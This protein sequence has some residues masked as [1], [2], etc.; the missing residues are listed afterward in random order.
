VTSILPGAEPFPAE[1]QA[2]LDS[3]WAEHEVKHGRSHAIAEDGGSRY[4]NRL[5]L[6]GSPYLRQHAHNPVNWYPWGDEAFAAAQSQRRPVFL[7]IGYSTCHWCHVM[8]DESFADPAIAAFLNAHY[9]AIKVDREERPDIDAVYMRAAQELGGGGGWPLSVWLTADRRPFFAGTYFPPRAGVRGATIGLLEILTELVL[10]Y[11]EDQARVHAVAREV[12]EAVR[13]SMQS[14]RDSAAPTFSLSAERE[15]RGLVAAAVEACRTGFDERHGGLRL[16]QKFPS[17]VPIRL[18]LRHHLRTGDAHALHM[19]VRTLEGMAG[20][21]IYDHLAGGFHRYATDPGWQVPHFEKMLYDNALLVVAYAE[22][23]QVTKRPDFARVVRET[24]DELLATFASRQG[25]FW[26]A[27]DAD[28]EGV[29][30]RYFAWSEAEIRAV[31]GPGDQTELFL[32]HYG[33]SAAGNFELGNILHVPRLEEDLTERLAPSR[34]KLRQARG[35]RVPPLRDEKILAAWNGLTISAFAVAGRVFDEKRYIDAAAAAADFILRGM[36]DPRGGR[37][38]RSWFEG[39]TSGPGFL[40]D[41]A[42]V[43]AGLLDLFESTGDSR[44]FGEACSLAEECEGRFADPDL[45]GWFM[46]GEEHEPLL[47]RERPLRDGAEPSGAS[48]ALM[49]AA[50]LAVYTDDERWR[51]VAARAL[52]FYAPILEEHPMAMTEA[53]IAVDFLAG[54]VKE[55]VLALPEGEAASAKPFHEVLRGTF[56]PRKVVV[57]GAPGPAG[58]QGLLEH[59]PALRDK[60][61]EP[62]MATAYVCEH[63]ACQAPTSDPESFLHL[64]A[65]TPA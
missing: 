8:E 55:I 56:C 46:T 12:V 2:R 6:E 16:Q 53:L 44:W 24:C 18:C 51:Q 31:L 52:H 20:G 34:A 13:A 33:V 15:G 3:A 28:S 22:A 62:G 40:D 59:I 21:G 26:S 5:A 38:A 48:V 27:T 54:P 9:V 47:G 43:T 11:D 58:W 29:E 63:G 37:L 60:A 64:I 39:R 50:R 61:T 25:G 45:G 42:F 4:V 41:Y 57:T 65:E 10:V 30:G 49:N 32:R 35:L 17:H 7:S 14:G 19:A 23:W 1:L 36:R